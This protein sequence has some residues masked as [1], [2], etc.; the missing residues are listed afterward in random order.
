VLLSVGVGGIAY[1]SA[2]GLRGRLL[3][4]TAST[5][6]SVQAL[7][8]MRDAQAGVM[9]VLQSARA[10]RSMQM[11]RLAVGLA[12]LGFE[13]MDAA[14]SAFAAVPRS[15]PVEASWSAAQKAIDE[16]SAK[17]AD[18]LAALEG[19]DRAARTGDPEAI[20]SA[21][22]KLGLAFA[23]LGTANGVSDAAFHDLGEAVGA[24]VA[25]V[26]EEGER[27]ARTAL[28]VVVT[29]IL[30]GAFAMALVALD[31][32]R[33][34]RRSLDGLARE[35]GRIA[36]ALADGDL[37]MRGDPA[38]VDREFRGIVEG[39]NAIA[40]AAAE[41]IRTTSTSLQLL[42]RGEVPRPLEV[43]WR[44][45]FDVIKESLNGCIAA[46]NALV[47]D[48]TRLAEAGV[49]GDLAVRADPERHAGDFRR[50]IE[51]FNGTLDAVI[52]PLEDVAACVARIS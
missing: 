49:S 29:A 27:S 47:A 2:A 36:A 52:G 23:A 42:A 44:G 20:A 5:I 43:A 33:R 25:R 13:D 39:V 37:S 14:R 17:V 38:V 51:G 30:A 26:A 16:W 41:P 45:D 9:E 10:A 6:P 31:L 1:T 4:V 46:V 3:G 28:L 32:A 15:A 19:S 34:I 8:A 11:R 48:A 50:V 22:R 21:Q 40:E 35:S 7:G 24:D 12:Q 18:A